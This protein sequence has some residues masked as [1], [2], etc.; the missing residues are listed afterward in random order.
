M[1][2]GDDPRLKRLL[3]EW[4]VPNAPDTLDQRV[5]GQPTPWW[6]I[7]VTSRVRVP[8]PVAFAV[9]VLLVWLATVAVRD[10]VPDVQPTGTTYDLRGFQPVNSVKVRI[11]RSSDAI[12]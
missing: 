5:F 9:S 6:R 11:E 1:G 12:P 8:V 2:P 10:R 3:T 4:Q 7:L